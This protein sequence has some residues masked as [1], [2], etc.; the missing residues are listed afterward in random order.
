MKTTG[1]ILILL[2]I[3]GAAFAGNPVPEIDAN[4]GMAAF[5]L[6]SGGMVVLWGR[7]RNK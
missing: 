7:R 2:G 1:L 6:I 5:A 3:A 4:S